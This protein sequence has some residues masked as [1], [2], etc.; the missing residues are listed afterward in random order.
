[1][2]KEIKHF[3]TNQELL[4]YLKGSKDAE[5][6]IPEYEESEGK[7]LR[8]ENT[9]SEG[10]KEPEDEESEKTDERKEA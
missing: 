10:N 4:Q 2:A 5:L 9:E 1:M 7:E 8:D 3:S 6:Q